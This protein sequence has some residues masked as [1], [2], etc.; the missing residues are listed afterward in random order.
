MF[1]VPKKLWNFK[2]T[3]Q[4]NNKKG[5]ERESEKIPTILKDERRSEGGYQAKA[6]AEQS[7]E[8]VRGSAAIRQEE[9]SSCER[10]ADMRWQWQ[11]QKGR[12]R[13]LATG[14]G[15]ERKS[16]T[17][18]GEGKGNEINEEKG[19]EIDYDKGKGGGGSGERR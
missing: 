17:S 12:E 1:Q 6:M 10:G 15:R 14:W 13:R 7:G 9:I 11:R 4:I 5:R 19:E 3:K 16:A 18:T 8:N 2:V